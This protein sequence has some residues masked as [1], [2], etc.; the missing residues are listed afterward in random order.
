MGQRRPGPST[1]NAECYLDRVEH[2]IRGSSVKDAPTLQE[3]NKVKRCIIMGE[4]QV[5][6]RRHGSATLEAN[7]AIRRNVMTELE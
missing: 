3:A 4:G 2:P 6:K 7:L 5:M 1:Q